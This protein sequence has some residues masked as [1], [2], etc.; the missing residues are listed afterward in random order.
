MANSY[1]PLMIPESYKPKKRFMELA[2]AEA[3]RA[4]DRGDY[5]IGAVITRI[6]GGR[7]VVIASAGNRVKTSGS[8]IKHVELE[9]LKYV[10]SGYGRYLEDFVLYSTHEPCAMCA[11]AC[12]WSRI[13]AV[14]FGV[15]Q[16]DIAAFGRKNGTEY[17]KWRACLIPCEFVLKKGNHVVPVTG[18]FLRRECQKLFRY[19]PSHP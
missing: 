13:G 5:P 18:G 19:R 7:E 15:S 17:Y 9:T 2:I 12:V 8:S 14:V 11:G 6:S 16:E 10:S 3:R 4:G 1:N